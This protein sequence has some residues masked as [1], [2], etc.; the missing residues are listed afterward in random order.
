MTPRDERPRGNIIP[1]PAAAIRRHPSHAFVTRPVIA[2]RVDAR[3]RNALLWLALGSLLAAALAVLVLRSAGPAAARRAH[4]RSHAA[5]EPPPAARAPV[6][7]VVPGS[8]NLLIAGLAAGNQAGVERGGLS[9]AIMLLHLDADRGRAWLVS[10]PPDTR[11]EAA[12]HGDDR[13]DAAYARGGPGAFIG[14]IE[15]LT[16]L[17]VDHVAVIDDDGLRTLTDGVGGVALSLDGPAGP[18]HGGLALEM[19]GDMAVDYVNERP[20]PGASEPDR[21]RREHHVLR[22]LLARLLERDTLADPGAVRDLAAALGAS[23][24]VDATLSPARLMAL[25]DSAK[26]LRLE[27]VTFL[28]APAQGVGTQGAPGAGDAVSVELWDAMARDELPTFVSMH[29]ELVTPATN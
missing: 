19:N 15:R 9:E 1:F 12:G 18:V 28:T 27:D 3:Q 17:P 10:I 11:V 14:A 7:R 16:G 8:V 6:R 21:I 29:P 2:P 25:L 20:A 23:V 4:A 26:H 5:A 13:I 22:A 24:R